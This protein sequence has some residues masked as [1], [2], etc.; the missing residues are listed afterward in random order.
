MR[1]SLLLAALLAL[2]G[3]REPR[4][5]DYY[6]THPAERAEQLRKLA[7]DPARYG[8]DADLRNAAE[9]ER[10]VSYGAALG[11]GP[12]ASRDPLGPAPAVPPTR[13]TRGPQ[14]AAQDNWD[15]ARG[16]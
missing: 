10:V 16:R 12:P 4:S 2:G 3:C 7:R 14:G 15:R 11:A 5:V 13:S 1:T 8:E 6:L 9:A